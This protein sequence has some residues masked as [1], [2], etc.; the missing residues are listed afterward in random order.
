M[1]PDKNEMILSPVVE[2]RTYLPDAVSQRTVLI[3]TDIFSDGLLLSDISTSDTQTRPDRN[4]RDRRAKP[5]A[6]DARASK[7]TPSLLPPPRSD[8]YC[9]NE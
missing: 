5:R 8:D 4:E 1:T 6:D 9:S 7:S 2:R 3:E